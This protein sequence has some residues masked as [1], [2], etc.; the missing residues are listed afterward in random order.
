VEGEDVGVVELGGDLDFAQEPGGA[1]GGGDFGP[2]D[3]DGYRAAVLLIQGEVD[4]GHAAPAQL[5]LDA[6]PSGEASTETLGDAVVRWHGVQTTAKGPP[7]AT[8]SG[9]LRWC[10]G[11][12]GP[13]G[14]GRGSRGPGRR[15]LYR[16]I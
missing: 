1:D 4:D 15:R 10:G 3:L 14:C 7:S 8:A 12:R 13:G 5:P 16:G 6:V 11:R 9:G 2:Q